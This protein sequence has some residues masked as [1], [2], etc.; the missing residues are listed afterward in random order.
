MVQMPE[1]GTRE[2]LNKIRETLTGFAEV[3]FRWHK[4]TRERPSSGKLLS[5]ATYGSR[6]GRFACQPNPRQPR[7]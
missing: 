7:G 5:T 4:I 3:K 1:R 6:A 2:H